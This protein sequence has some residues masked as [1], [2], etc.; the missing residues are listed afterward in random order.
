MELIVLWAFVGLLNLLILTYQDI[1][2]HMIIDD[3][4]NLV[5]LGLTVSLLS[6]GYFRSWYYLALIVVVLLLTNWIGKKQFFGDGDV[7]A[8]R[9]LFLGFGYIHPLSF[10]IFGTNLLLWSAAHMGAKKIFKIRGA[11]PYFAVILASFTVTCLL[12]GFF[13]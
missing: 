1:K 12:M 7:S 9:W 4:K 11:T 5:M 3:R 2:N 10:A 8:F 13:W 6:L